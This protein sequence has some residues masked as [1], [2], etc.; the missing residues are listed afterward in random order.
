[1]SKVTRAGAALRFCL[2]IAP[3]MTQPAASQAASPQPVLDPKDIV[4]RPI[5]SGSGE[6]SYYPQ[7]A[8]EMG[9]EGRVIMLCD[10][11]PDQSLSCAAESETPPNMEFGASAVRL[12]SRMRLEPLTKNGEPVSGRQVRITFNFRLR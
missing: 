11:G 8:H 7:R 3:A 4:Y 5:Q 2:S 6:E 9:V 1:M 10:I 12:F